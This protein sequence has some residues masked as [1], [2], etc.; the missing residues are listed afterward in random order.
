MSPPAD[1]EGSDIFVPLPT[2]LALNKD[3]ID[4]GS[5]G[6]GQYS[7]RS[8]TRR[9]E[10]SSDTEQPSLETLRKQEKEA[11]RAVLRAKRLQDEVHKSPLS[12][13]SLSLARS[14]RLIPKP[15]HHPV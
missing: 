13:L 15:R 12:R 6:G 11:R 3:V 10:I 9:S 4:K 7:R 2:N 1:A 8:S 5:S 14:L